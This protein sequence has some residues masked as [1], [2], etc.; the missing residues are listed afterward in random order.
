MAKYKGE[1]ISGKLGDFI[2]SSWHGRPYKKRRPESVANPQTE[3][4]QAHRSAFAE[5]SRLSSAMKEAHTEGLHWKAVRDKLDT[6][7]I[8]KRL[9]KDCYG[10]DG[11]DYP[12]ISISYGTLRSVTVTAAEVDAQGNV[13]VEFHDHYATEKN[14]N[15]LFFLFVFCPDLREGHYAKPVERTIGVVDA[16]IPEEWLGHTLHLYAFMKGSK[17]RTS[18]TIYVGEFMN[19]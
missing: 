11:I 1:E 18:E 4:Q 9:N 7:S 10:P 14:K 17:G 2:Y 16:I 13:H 3:L 12:C 5:M 8:F 19:T 6:H 15:D